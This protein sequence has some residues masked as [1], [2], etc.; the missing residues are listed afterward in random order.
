MLPAVLWTLALAVRHLSSV[1][2]IVRSESFQLALGTNGDVTEVSPVDLFPFAVSLQLLDGTA[3]TRHFC[4]GTYLSK[5]WILTAAHCV[6]SINYTQIVAQIGGLDL[7]DDAPAERYPVVEMHILRTYNPI[8]MVGDIALLRVAMAKEMAYT[9]DNH[10]SLR[11]PQR[12]DRTAVNGEMCYIFGYG[13]EAYDGPI[14][15]KLR[16]GTV[17]ALEEDNCIGM[18]GA[19]VAPPP[20]S[21]MFC[22]IGRSDACK[23][24]SGGGY[25]CRVPS[26][27]GP[28]VLRG[29]ISYGVGCGAVGTPG[30][31][32]DVAYYLHHFQPESVFVAA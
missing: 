20:N 9:S 32:T 8:T 14:S 5:G 4:G 7:N 24:D 13:S 1:H 26:S 12:T 31:Y 25:V 6:I 3:Q 28:F 15:Q 23:G 11:L 18:M 17:L 22:A 30:V 16:Y 19:V 27:F 2:A 21:G 29:V 10:T